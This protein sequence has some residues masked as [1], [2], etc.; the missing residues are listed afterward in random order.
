MAFS[1]RRLSAILRKEVQD[2]KNN[3]Q[4]LLL[5]LLPIGLAFFYKQL[6][7]GKE[8]MGGIVVVMVMSMIVTIAQA[9]LIAEEKEKH[10]LRVLMLSPASPIEVIVGKSLPIIILSIVLNFVSL[11]LLN[12][13][14][15]SILLLSVIIVIG[16]LLFIILGTLVGLLAKSLVQVSVITTPISMILLMGP[17][18]NE[19]IKNE[20]IKKVV[21]Y[22]PTNHIFE[23]IVSVV[24]GKGFSVIQTN[25]LNISIWLVITVI[26]CMFVYKKKQ[27]D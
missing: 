7:S 15:G 14:Q 4:I 23:A 9:T 16:T 21:S 20:M 8:M 19:V 24:N 3:A 13:L 6:G 22:L 17:I 26:V 11:F 12:V 10:T 1:M 18:L 25:L 5:A 2:L 27:L